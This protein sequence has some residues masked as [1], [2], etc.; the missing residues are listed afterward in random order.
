[1]SVMN[2]CVNPF[3]VKS[4]FLL[5][6]N[7]IKVSL[8]KSNCAT[9]H[10]NPV[11][12]GSQMRINNPFLQ[13]RKFISTIVTGVVTL[14]VI[15]SYNTAFALSTSKLFYPYVSCFN[16]LFSATG[17]LEE[18][19]RSFTDCS[20]GKPVE[21]NNILVHLITPQLQNM[22]FAFY[23]EDCLHF[24]PYF[25]KLQVLILKNTTTDYFCL[26]SIGTHCAEY[27]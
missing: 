1:M 4:L 22:R 17:V 25:E 3:Q 6:K 13:L 10:L 18:L 20:S 12:V 15:H 5:C 11:V 9:S 19:I 21:N 27:R 14:Y 7:C 23:S 8:T 24:F 16:K 26:R 2:I